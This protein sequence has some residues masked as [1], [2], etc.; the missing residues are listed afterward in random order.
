M[1]LRCTLCALT[2]PFFIAPSCVLGLSFFCC[3]LFADVW[4]VKMNATLSSGAAENKGTNGKNT[5]QKSTLFLHYLPERRPPS[6]PP[7]CSNPHREAR[8]LPDETPQ[9]IPKNIVLGSRRFFFVVVILCAVGAH[10]GQQRSTYTKLC[11]VTHPPC[12]SL[13]PFVF[14]AHNWLCAI[15]VQ[16]LHLIL[17]MR[18][19]AAH[20]V[21]LMWT[22]YR[23]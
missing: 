17:F 15:N 12:F 10:N 1:Q 20:N 13:F 23:T 6:W 19:A 8:S 7:N 5:D 16:Q 4:R 22:L 9:N 3:C 11:P 14:V 21:S 18:N 2:S